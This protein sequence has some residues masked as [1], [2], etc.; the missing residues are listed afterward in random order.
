ME[1]KFVKWVTY[2]LTVLLA[3]TFLPGAFM[4]ITQHP[5]VVQGIAHIGIP[6]AAIVPIGLLEMA[7]LV[8][9]L[10]PR[11]VVLGTFLLTGYLG[12]AVMANIINHSDFIHALVIGLLVW[13]AALLRVAELR[14]LLPLRSSRQSAAEFTRPETGAGPILTSRQGEIAMAAA[15]E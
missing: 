13:A 10:I 8:L 6:Q 12:G 14:N 2:S 9:F 3:L 5:M 11:T 1:S 4:K 15:S 7:C